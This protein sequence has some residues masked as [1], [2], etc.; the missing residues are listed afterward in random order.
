MDSS[1]TARLPEL[2][3]LRGL[4]ILFVLIFHYGPGIGL[5][6]PLFQPGAPMAYVLTPFIRLGWSGVDLFFVLSGFLIC[7]VIIS[8][9]DVPS[10]LTTFYARRAARILP[11]YGMLLVIFIAGIAA[12]RGGLVHLPWLFGDVR[13]VWPY[14]S[15]MQ[16]NA[17]AIFG[18]EFNFFTPTWSLAIEEQFYL[19]FPIIVGLLPL[20]SRLLVALTAFIATSIVFR[21][22]AFF[23][24]LSSPEDFRFSFTL[25]RLDGLS[26]GATIAVLL[27]DARWRLYL[28]KRRGWFAM[29]IPVLALG[30]LAEAKWQGVLGPLL[31]TWFSLLYGV[32]LL[33]AVL[34][35][36]LTTLL[37]A[38]FLRFLGDI[39]YGLYLLHLPVMGLITAVLW[40]SDL[41][42]LEPRPI[43]CT[44]LGVAASVLLA[45]ASF[46]LMEQPILRAV[47]H[48]YQYVQPASKNKLA[49]PP[50]GELKLDTPVVD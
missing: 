15:F 35:H 23:L 6:G 26:I 32:I 27:R 29:A 33:V 7:N 1:N 9:R 36:P 11:L 34:G 41:N 17:Y 3:G 22:L 42:Y 14:W 28:E 8:T 39:S 20:R 40:S 46:R 2:D 47:R 5:G 38:R 18:H 19:C 21:A 16:N 30:A 49:S 10:G 4:A 12:Q 48:R 24:P 50:S 44:V 37:R 45:L 25:C 13:Q 43:I 31:Y